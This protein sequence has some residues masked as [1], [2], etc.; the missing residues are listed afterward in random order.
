MAAQDGTAIGMIPAT[1]VAVQ[2]VGIEGVQYDANKFSWL[3][4]IGTSPETLAV[5]HTAG[6]RT[7]EEARQKELT[8]AASNPGAATFIFPR[9]LNELIGTKL[10]LVS[11]YQGNSTMI[12]AMERG[13]VDAVSNSWD[14]WKA[15]NPDWIKDKKINLLVQTEPKAED[16]DI[17]SVQELA[18][19]DD[20]L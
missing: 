8:V 19:N 5:W 3:G 1:L 10:K 12:V 14:S 16:L 11:G 6:V 18:C 17:P 15:L 20:D 2:A 13:E 7:I 4:T 9:M